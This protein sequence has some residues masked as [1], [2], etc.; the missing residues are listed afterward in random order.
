VLA[1]DK[2]KIPDETKYT[3]KTL[4]NCTYPLFVEKNLEYLWGRAEIDVAGWAAFRRLVL[5]ENYA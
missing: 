5:L 3:I 2:S 4:E 1:V